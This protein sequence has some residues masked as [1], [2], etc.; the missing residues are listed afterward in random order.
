MDEVF[1]RLEILDDDRLRGLER[2]A[3]RRPQICRQGSRP[4]NA[5]FPS[6][7]GGDEQVGFA[8]AISKDFDVIDL[9]CSCDL[10]HDLVEKSI[11]VAG[12]TRN[13][14]QIDKNADMPPNLVQRRRLLFVCF[15]RH[16]HTVNVEAAELCHCPIRTGPVR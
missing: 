13:P 11:L 4:H 9:H 6:E 3:R 14:G 2:A 12:F 5:L 7:A 15:L 8:A 10:H 1:L 16:R